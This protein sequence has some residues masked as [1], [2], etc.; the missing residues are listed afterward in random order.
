MNRIFPAVADSHL[1]NFAV[2]PKFGRDKNI[3]G[4]NDVHEGVGQAVIH[5]LQIIFR[6][7]QLIVRNFVFFEKIG[8]IGYIGRFSNLP[9]KRQNFGHSGMLEQKLGAGLDIP[10]FTREEKNHKRPDKQNHEQYR[11]PGFEFA[12][13]YYTKV[14]IFDHCLS[15]SG[16]HTAC[17]H[18]PYT[19]TF[20]LRNCHSSPKTA[21]NKSI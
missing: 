18:A 19:Y 12:V 9:I 6:D 4:I 8:K 3:I 10:K 13:F 16:S 15:F 11:K 20:L 14:I 21:D 17:M 7:H 2:S 1:V 5:F